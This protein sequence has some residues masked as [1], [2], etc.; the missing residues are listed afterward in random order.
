MGGQLFPTK[1]RKQLVSK[2]ESP[3]PDYTETPGAS[4][5]P[6]LPQIRPLILTI[7]RKVVAPWNLEPRLEEQDPIMHKGRSP[8][9]DW[10]HRLDGNDKDSRTYNFPT[11]VL[12][13][14]DK[15][16]AS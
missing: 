11:S 12:P 9:P 3:T 4:R 15:T 7:Y 14:S 8:A 10:Q 6:R 1:R 16:L 13:L 2:N 5:F